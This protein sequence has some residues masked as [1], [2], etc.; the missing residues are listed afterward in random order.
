[1]LGITIDT[2]GVS[3]G[4]NHCGWTGGAYYNGKANGRDGDAAF[5]AIYDYVAESGDLLFQVCRKANK[6]FPQRRPDGKGGWIW[7]TKGVTKVLYRLP[8]LIAAIAAGETILIVEG[9]KDVNAAW[10]LVFAATCNPGGA[11]KWRS[12]YNEHFRGADV[13]LV[14]DNDDPGWGHVN[15]IGAAL[16]GVAARV[17]VL[18]LPGLPPSGDLSDWIAAGGTRE[19]LETLIAEAPDW[20]APSEPEAGP[21]VEEARK[22]DAAREQALPDELARLDR[23]DYERRRRA[24]VRRDQRSD[25]ISQH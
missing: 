23:L 1:M 24:A 2:Q 19:Q 25:L 8:E 21:V 10:R 4:C 7:G 5:V 13:V 18:V 9:K 17:R 11:G 3:W 6:S 12:E 14:P 16:D 15:Q 20:S 22:T